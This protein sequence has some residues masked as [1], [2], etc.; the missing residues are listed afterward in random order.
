MSATSAC[1]G[2]DG[3]DAAQRTDAENRKKTSAEPDDARMTNW[4]F[5]GQTSA[6]HIPSLPAVH[7]RFQDD[8]DVPFL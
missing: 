2:H 8:C 1:Q 5:L 4:R 3:L 6:S 7:C